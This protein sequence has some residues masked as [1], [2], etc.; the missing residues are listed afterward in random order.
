MIKRVIAHF[1]RKL[2]F[3]IGAEFY[4][5]MTWQD[6]WRTH[7]QEL[8][9]QFKLETQSPRVL[10]VGIGPGVSALSIKDVYPN[11]EVV[12]LDFSSRMIRV[13]ERYIARTEHDVELVCADATNMPFEDASF[14]V[15]TGHS[16]LYLVPQKQAVIKEIVRVLKPG[17]R[18]VFLEPQEGSAHRD[19]MSMRGPF[20]FKL[21]MFLWKTVSGSIGPF[22]QDGLRDLLA[23][24]F[25]DVEV[26]GTLNDMGVWGVAT[27][28]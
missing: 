14:D 22:T 26:E 8:A 24:G 6:V 9:H 25:D 27:K 16:F 12:G 15:V 28:R 4:A 21:S 2:M 23:E 13:A 20:K 5:W 17:G 7:C 11:S 18:C 19:W 3:D 10:D 1:P